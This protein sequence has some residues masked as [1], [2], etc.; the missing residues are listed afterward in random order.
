MS[1]EDA[2]SSRTGL[3]EDH[4]EAL[5]ETLHQGQKV[6]D[7]DD[8]IPTSAASI[9][10]VGD[11]AKL[12][13]EWL[14]PATLED[15]CATYGEDAQQLGEVHDWIEWMVDHMEEFEHLSL[16]ASRIRVLWYTRV[17][18]KQDVVV[19]GRAKALG[20]RE[21]ILSG[22]MLWDI[23]LS[24]VS[25]ALRT[26]EQRARLLHHELYHLGFNDAGGP[27]TR[28]HSIED[29]DA[30]LGRFGAREDQLPSIYNAVQHRS[31]TVVTP[32]WV[33]QQKAEGL[34]FEA[35]TTGIWIR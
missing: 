13:P 21:Q 16:H 25:W 8:A 10:T 27:G 22:G 5:V 9:K 11:A 29:N 31:Y 7:N 1:T 34:V 18:R 6:L 26:P 35:T 28:P 23:E 15:F 30:T 20:V 24:L 17:K 2:L 32:P 3:T 4:L 19:N 12:L 33:E 14:I